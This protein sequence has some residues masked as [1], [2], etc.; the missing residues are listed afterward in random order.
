MRYVT[1]FLIGLLLVFYLS[2]CSFGVGVAYADDGSISFSFPNPM[3]FYVDGMSQTVSIARTSQNQGFPSGSSMYT[4]IAP[5]VFGNTVV[6]GYG[7]WQAFANYR[8]YGISQ[9]FSVPVNFSVSGLD[10]QDLSFSYDPNFVFI[11]IQRPN[12]DAGINYDFS[13]PYWLFSGTATVNFSDGSSKTINLSSNTT[14]SFSAKKDNRTNMF[15]LASDNAFDLNT[16][17]SFKM[18][19]KTFDISGINNLDLSGSGDLNISGGSVIA[20]VSGQ[21]SGTATLPDELIADIS[22]YRG[23]IRTSDYTGRI[24]SVHEPSGTQH[25][26]VDNV[27]ELEQNTT[28]QP[29]GVHY[30]NMYATRLAFYMDDPLVFLES[31]S[32]SFAETSVQLLAELVNA[33]VDSFTLNKADFS[34]NKANLSAKNNDVTVSSGSASV[35]NANVEA[36]VE[37]SRAEPFITVTGFSVSGDFSFPVQYFDRVFD[38]TQPFSLLF[39]DGSA[40]NSWGSY[41]TLTCNRLY[42]YGE[43]ENMLS[44]IAS[45]LDGIYYALR[46]DLPLTIRH[47]LIPTTEEVQDVVND[48]VE[49]V[50]NNA[51][52]LGQAVEATQTDIEQLKL[53]LQGGS[54]TP[55]YIPAAVVNLGSTSYTL[56]DDFDVS[57][58]FQLEPIQSMTSYLVPFL[59]FLVA[60]ALIYHLNAMWW[61]L[62]SGSSYFGFL[63]GIHVLYDRE[64]DD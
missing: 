30:F 55:L 39:P 29:I 24:K 12:G 21:V 10:L 3:S 5:S 7:A 34:V 9:S 60:S 28:G 18:G 23:N 62:L 1:Q 43:S 61:A 35:E 54:S 4:A 19:S 20:P 22:S 56:W 59:E 41:L 52:G 45:T 32:I 48:A 46:V 50:K 8:V 38:F 44:H 40:T 49:E 27:I 31:A 51:G 13:R 11:A 53:F 2:F 47:L 14:L 37:I 17:E 33:K 63:K 26:S 25:F 42:T 16:D 58:Y 64:D 15:N 6:A 57:P 36:L